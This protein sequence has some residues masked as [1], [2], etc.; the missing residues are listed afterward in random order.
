MEL[1]LISFFQ[2]KAS[3]TIKQHRVYMIDVLCQVQDFSDPIDD[4]KILHLAK[5]QKYRST[6]YTAKNIE[7]EIQCVNKV[8]K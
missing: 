6:S 3:L 4:R 5:L 1:I 7:D 2:S 8:P